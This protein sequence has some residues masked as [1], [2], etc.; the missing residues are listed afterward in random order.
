MQK[1]LLINGNF[2]LSGPSKPKVEALYIEGGKITALGTNEELKLQ[3]GRPQVQL[4][5]LEGAYVLPGLVD[6]HLHLPAHGMKLSTLDL[7][8]ARSKEELLS[9]VQQR[10]DV[11]PEGEWVIGLNWNENAF[12]SPVIPTLEE[13]DQLSARHPIFLSRT[14]SHA[15]MA[16]SLAFS[17]AGVHPDTTDPTGGSFGRQ[18]DGRFNGMIYELASEPFYAAQPQ[19]DYSMKKDFVRAAIQDA[20]RLG[21]TAAHTEDLRY[22]GDLPTVLRIYKELKEEGLFFRTHHLIYHPHLAELDELSLTAGDGD[23]WLRIGAVKIFSDGAIGGRT[24]LLSQPYHDAPHTSGMAMHSQEELNEITRQARA[25]KMPIAV[26]AIGDGGA[27]LTIQAME[28]YPVQQVTR[29]RDRLIHAQVL[30]KDLIDRLQRLHV[31]IDIQPRF[32]ASDFPWVLERVGASRKDYLYAWKT[33]LQ[34]G[35]YCG[36]GSDAPIEPLDPLLGLHAAMTRR[37][38]EESH[39]GYLENEKLTMSEAIRLFT[40]GSA[41]TACEEHERGRLSEGY[42]ADLTVLDRDLLQVDPDEVLQAKVKMTVVNGE[43]AYRG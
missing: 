28:A 8:G 42:Y 39:A 23:E 16:N 1:R 4:V 5:D 17:R 15:H 31:A 29:Y 38:P 27:E 10:V 14:C 40:V 25:R 24:A 34:A 2:Y 20:L 26:H 7:S 33:L 12:A 19:A 22:L 18:E 9:L 30:R 37:S 36:G 35:L 3:W 6:N 41:Q 32:V 21:L 11:T 43:I 13:L